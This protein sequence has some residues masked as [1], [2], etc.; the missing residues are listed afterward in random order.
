MKKLLIIIILAMITIFPSIMGNSL[1]LFN[2]NEHD[3]DIIK[4]NEKILIE[5][6]IKFRVNTNET[7]KQIIF[8][9][10][11]LAQDIQFKL[12]DNEIEFSYLKNNNYSVNISSYNISNNSIINLNIN[13]FIEEDYTEFKKIMIYDTNILS[14]NFNDENIFNANHLSY[15]SEILISLYTPTEA[16]ISIYIFISIFLILLLILIL[17]YYIFSKQKKSKIKN[18]TGESKELLSTK[19]ILLMSILKQLEKEYRAKKISDDTYNKLRD[20]YKQEAVESMKKL[21]DIESEII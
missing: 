11:E 17:T 7:N 1:N 21:E 10:S 18:I 16:P 19:K 9:I 6:N 5:E 2:V 12:F 13:Y 15:N 20:L 14:I 4:Q 8:W 3:I